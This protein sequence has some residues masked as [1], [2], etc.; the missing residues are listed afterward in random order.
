MAEKTGISWCDSTFNIAWGC[1]RVSEACRFCY[2]EALS[3]RFGFDIWGADKPRRIFGEKHWQEPLKWNRIAEHEGRRHRVFCSSMADVFEDHPTIAQERKKL[4]PLIRQTPNLDWLLLTK[5][6]DNIIGCLPD[7]WGAGW[8][9]V[10]LGVTA[11]NQEWFDKR[12]GALWYLKQKYR[13]TV[14]FVSCEPLLGSIDAEWAVESIELQERSIE[15]GGAIYSSPI[16]WLIVGGESG[17]NHR[18]L[19]LDHVRS[20]RDQC[21]AAGVAFHFKQ[22]GGLRP[23]SGGCELDGREWK[24]FPQV[25]VSHA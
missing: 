15:D 14:M 2:A 21:V 9:N 8:P 6:A 25:E 10:W 16:D 18:P 24:R 19:N 17:P 13:D 22:I 7:D 12:V 3:K 11:E 20:L 4:W 1:V 5:R 23:D